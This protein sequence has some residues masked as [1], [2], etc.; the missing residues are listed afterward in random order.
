MTTLLLLATPL[1]L[2][3]L[4]WVS[5]GVAAVILVGLMGWRAYFA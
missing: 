5:V 2:L 4:G 3:A 1:V